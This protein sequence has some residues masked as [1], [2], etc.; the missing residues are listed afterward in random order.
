MA[1]ILRR[2]GVLS[3]FLPTQ[4][5]LLGLVT[6]AMFVLLLLDEDVQEQ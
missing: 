5:A 4:D 3:A 6:G 1:E 2:W